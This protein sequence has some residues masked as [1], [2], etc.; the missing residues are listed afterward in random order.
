MDR[1]IMDE[2]YNFFLDLDYMHLDS[3]FIEL[4]TDRGEKRYNNI[5]KRI[6]DSTFH[7]YEKFIFEELTPSEIFHYLNN[8]FDSVFFD[9]YSTLI[10]K[11]NKK[12]ELISK[13]KLGAQ[14]YFSNAYR[15]TDRIEVSSSSHPF[16]IPMLAHEYSHILFRKK[17]EVKYAENICNIHYE[18]LPSIIME[19]ITS[20]EMGYRL[21]NRQFSDY[22]DGFRLNKNKAMLL[23]LDKFSKKKNE[24]DSKEF[25]D[26]YSYLK[27]LFFGYII[28][29]IYATRFIDFYINDRKDALEKYRDLISGKIDVVT[30]INYFEIG[31]KDIKTSGS[32]V[33]KIDK[34]RI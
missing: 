26:C 11:C 31:I 12:V 14:T 19:K 2:V 15:V 23:K 29:D 10:K 3:T 28:S 1:K 4:R 7:D 24:D 9:K 13:S 21:S 25:G 20:I 22:I 34:L 18:E 16:I 32:Y 6:N 30:F 27:H 33:K 8:I 17:G 5:V